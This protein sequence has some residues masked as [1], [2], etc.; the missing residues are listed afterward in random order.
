MT[1]ILILLRIFI[2][3]SLVAIDSAKQLGISVNLDVFDTNAK[4][5]D[6]KIILNQSNFSKYDAILGPITSQN[7]ELTANHVL[8]DS[9]PVVSPFV[10]SK[11]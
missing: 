1:A 9:I 5:L 6:V 2:L 4:A 11:K 3:V 8:L 7:L 10:R